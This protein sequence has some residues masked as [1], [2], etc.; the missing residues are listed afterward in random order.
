M[1]QVIVTSSLKEDLASF[2]EFN[3]FRVDV[4]SETIY[5]VERDGEL[6]VFINL[7]GGHLYF[8]IDLGNI[9]SVA[10]EKL[11]HDLLDLNTE[12]LPVAFGLN[13]ANPDDPRLVL[14]ES[15]EAENLDSN[16]LLCVFTTLELAVDRA[17]TLLADYLN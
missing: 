2:L 15:R 9:S 5:R 14:V 13:R 11:Y 3:G 8:E 7:E 12:I 6:P 10:T 1:K 16:E 17:E 4:L